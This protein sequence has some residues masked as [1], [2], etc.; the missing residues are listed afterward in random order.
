MGAAKQRKLA[1]A[2]ISYC[3]SCTLCCTLPTIEALNKPAYQPCC[4]LKDSGCALFGHEA[5][6][7]TCI[8][9]TC[10]YLSKRLGETIAL[11]GTHDVP[12]PSDCGAYFHIHTTHNQTHEKTIF[13]FV[14]PAK[15]ERWKQSRLIDIFRLALTQGISLFITDRGRTMLIKQPHIF[16]GVLTQ[17]MVDYADREGHPR[18]I[19]S[20][21][22][23][24]LS[25]SL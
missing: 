24:T 3:R 5:R 14:D 7:Q 13:V 25:S 12:H 20:Y 15:P 1:G 22:P 11:E 8:A 16:E 4:H 6:P 23:A 10:A 2:R 9:Y 17:D 18:D 21:D 19:P